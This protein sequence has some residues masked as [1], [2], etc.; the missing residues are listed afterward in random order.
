MDK[1]SYYL[2]ALFLF[3]TILFCY[4]LITTTFIGNINEI[5][6]QNRDICSKSQNQSIFILSATFTLLTFLLFIFYCYYLYNY[7]SY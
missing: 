4:S 2:F 7:D 5:Q 1:D 6:Y 3:L